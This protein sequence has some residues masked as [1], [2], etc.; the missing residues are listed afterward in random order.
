MA[1]LEHSWKLVEKHH[2]YEADAL[3][4]ASAKHVKAKEFLTSDEKLHKNSLNR[5]A[6]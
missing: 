3:Q 4:V 2:I 1:I 5:G 6:E